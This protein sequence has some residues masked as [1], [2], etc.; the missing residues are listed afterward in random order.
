M[1]ERPAAAAAPAAVGTGRGAARGCP[2]RAPQ[3]ANGAE[4]KCFCSEHPPGASASTRAGPELTC[5]SK[6]RRSFHMCEKPV[7]TGAT[8]PCHTH[9][10]RSGLAARAGTHHDGDPLLR[11]TRGTSSCL[12]GCSHRL[13]LPRAPCNSGL[14][15]LRSPTP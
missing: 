14:F 9:V 3:R 7:P 5:R 2:C 1:G 8:G 4:P 6:G 10:L 11:G 12:K 15:V 13:Q